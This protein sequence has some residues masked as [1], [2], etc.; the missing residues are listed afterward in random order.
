MAEEKFAVLFG[1]LALSLALK[2]K[3]MWRD[4]SE[5]EGEMGGAWFVGSMSL[6]LHTMRTN[7]LF[8]PCEMSFLETWSC[9]FSMSRTKFQK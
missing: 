9:L 5:L 2:N 6:I 1:A 7:Q 8:S 3:F 4:A